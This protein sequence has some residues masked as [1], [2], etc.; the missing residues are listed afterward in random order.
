[1]S[2]AILPGGRPEI[3]RFAAE[4]LLHAAGV[5]TARPAILGRRG[6]YRDTMGTPGANDRGIYDD[7]ILIVSPSAYATFNANTDP[8]NQG[9]RLA[10]LALGLWL[11][12]LGTHHPGT[13][14]AYA[15]LVQAGAVTVSRDNGVT[16]SG[17][18]YIHIHR[19]G[20]ST[21]SSEGCQTLHPDQWD[22][23]FALVTGEMQRY[24]VATIPYLLTERT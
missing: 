10:T 16:E 24:H 4:A 13:P 14:N 18:F 17:E 15:C 9:G 12:K 2:P 3:G 22:A 23:F 19:G 5:D 8:S 21:T 6:Y 7:A 20:Y 11:Y 1:M